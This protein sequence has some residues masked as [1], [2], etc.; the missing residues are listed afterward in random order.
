VEVLLAHDNDRTAVYKS[1]TNSLK[2]SGQTDVAKLVKNALISPTCATKFLTTY[3]KFSISP[4]DAASITGIDKEVIKGFAVVL[5]VIP[6]GQ[7]MHNKAFNVY[8][9]VIAKL[10]V[11]KYPWSYLLASVQKI[12]IHRT[13]IIN[14][15]MSLIGQISEETWSKDMKRFR[16]HHTRKTSSQNHDRFIEHLINIFRPSCFKSKEIIPKMQNSTL[17]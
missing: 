4:T 3:K 2:E 9:L 13:Q 7:E 1:S 17:E 16:E 14:T 12:L 15:A 10:F 8:A 5:Q 6:C 11:Q